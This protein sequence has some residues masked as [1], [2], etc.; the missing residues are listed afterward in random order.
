[1]QSY[2]SPSSD[3]TGSD[4]YRVLRARLIEL[5][6]ACRG[7]AP[8]ADETREARSLLG[9]IVQMGVRPSD[10]GLSLRELG[11]SPARGSR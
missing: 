3:A 7:R 4:R 2:H 10:V 6:G 1:M 11:L 5:S 8:T 9:C